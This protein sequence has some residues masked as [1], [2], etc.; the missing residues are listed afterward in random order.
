MA[1]PCG[2]DVFDVRDLR[3]GRLLD[4]IIN[5]RVALTIDKQD[6]RLTERLT[7]RPSAHRPCP[8]PC[9]SLPRH[10]CPTRIV[11]RYV[12]NSTDLL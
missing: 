11:N 6:P 9:P 1:G 12:L 2:W 7:A 3:P 4:S 10:P 8:C 5:M